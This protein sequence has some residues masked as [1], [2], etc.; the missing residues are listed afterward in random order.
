LA[1]YG[2]GGERRGVESGVGGFVVT[3]DPRVVEELSDGI[4][5]VGVNGEEMRD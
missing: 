3:L 5:S 1:L 2:W 4:S